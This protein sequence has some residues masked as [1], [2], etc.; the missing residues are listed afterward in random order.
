MDGDVFGVKGSGGGL[1]RLRVYDQHIGIY[2]YM[3]EVYPYQM[4]IAILKD[5]SIGYNSPGIWKQTIHGGEADG[6][7]ANN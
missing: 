5:R 1:F 4:Y 6:S 3:W 7:F 2:I